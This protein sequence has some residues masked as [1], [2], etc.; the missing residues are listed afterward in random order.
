[1][2][3]SRYLLCECGWWDEPSFGDRWFSELR[4]PVCPKC[5][6]DTDDAKMVTASVVGV[7]RRRLVLHEGAA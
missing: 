2:R 7:L 4:Y 3:I 6:R 1:M 5:G